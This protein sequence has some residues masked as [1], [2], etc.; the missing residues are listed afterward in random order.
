MTL[1]SDV[2]LT[3]SRLTPHGWHSLLLQ[4]G[5]DITAADLHQELT[6]PLSVDRT[7]KG[8][9]DFSPSGVRGIEAARPAESLLYH[10]L[11]SPNV[12]ATADGTVV[13]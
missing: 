12:T 1:I 6:K 5:L 13:V 4:H 2:Q 10:A 8:F 7:I 3:C 9:E 11:A